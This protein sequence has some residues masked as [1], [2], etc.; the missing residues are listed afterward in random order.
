MTWLVHMRAPRALHRDL[1]WRSFWVGQTLLLGM[2][3]SALLHPLLVVTGALLVLSLA[4]DGF[5][6]PLHAAMM[7]MD[8]TN[9]A[10]AYMTFLLLAWRALPPRRRG[11]FALTVLF[12]PVYWMMMSLAAWRAVWQLN[13]AP[14]HWEKT[15]HRRRGAAPRAAAG[16]TAA[17]TERTAP[18]R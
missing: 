5:E 11:G 3:A 1:G 9:I 6:S 18:S 14:H 12:L 15:P 4:G 7:A 8:V 10:L 2:I 16:A 13:V 17:L